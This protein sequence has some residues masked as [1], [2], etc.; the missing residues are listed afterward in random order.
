MVPGYSEWFI[1]HQSFTVN[2]PAF[3]RRKTLTVPSRFK[4]TF[5]NMQ[6]VRAYLCKALCSSSSVSLIWIFSSD[7][8]KR[9][10][11]AGCAYLPVDISAR[12]AR[13]TLCS[14]AHTLQTHQVKQVTPSQTYTEHFCEADGLISST[15]WRKGSG[16]YWCIS[17][18]WCTAW[19]DFFL[20]AKPCLL[21]L[22]KQP[23]QFAST[24]IS[25][26]KWA[27]HIFQYDFLEWE[28]KASC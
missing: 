9:A 13:L 4:A 20:L 18:T 28:V 8:C 17:F 7:W 21:Y 15:W 24:L 22:H 5:K 27:Q 25:S 26:L 6:Q 10:A 2:P 23:N 16:T 1:S 14:A 3:H 11:L 19:N 12:A